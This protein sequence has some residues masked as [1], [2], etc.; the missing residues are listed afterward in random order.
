MA[1]IKIN[2]DPV[3]FMDLEKVVPAPAP[4]PFDLP[5]IKT[6]YLNLEARFAQM[7][8]K[9]DRG[10]K[11][12]WDK[13]DFSEFHKVLATSPMLRQADAA[14]EVKIEGEKAVFRADMRKAILSFENLDCITPDGKVIWAEFWQYWSQV[15]YIQNRILDNE[16]G[17]A[18]TY[19]LFQTV[20]I[21]TYQD[22]YV[23]L[24]PCFMSLFKAHD[25]GTREQPLGYISRGDM[26]YLT[27]GLFERRVEVKD[28]HMRAGDHVGERV[29]WADFWGFISQTALVPSTELGLQHTKDQLD[30]WGHYEETLV[31]EEFVAK[32]NRIPFHD[33]FLDNSF[34]YTTV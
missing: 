27:R 19:L 22:E 1:D 32:V 25:L 28:A 21:T 9:Y 24:K 18:D 10:Y 31:K 16:S 17:L 34:V 7:F 30:M 5:D 4:E 23:S 20:G 3:R 8:K 12:Y 2:A 11:G 14:Y 13:N 15:H 29:T 26:I 6:V 33:S